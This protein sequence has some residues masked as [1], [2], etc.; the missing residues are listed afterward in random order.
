MAALPFG[1]YLLVESV[2][3]L[4][5]L[6]IYHAL[7]RVA[8]DW[9][10]PV[11][12]ERLRTKDRTAGESLLVAARRAAALVHINLIQ[13]LDSGECAGDFFVVTEPW[14]ALDLARVGRTLDPV[15]LAYVMAEAARGL[16]A[17]HQAKA[18]HGGLC[19]ARIALGIRGEVKL[20]EAE[21]TATLARVGL[22]RGERRYGPSQRDPGEPLDA[23]SELYTLGQLFLE[24][25]DGLPPRLER[26]AAR[27][28]WKDGSHRYREAV[29]LER[30]L[31][32]FLREAGPRFR[33]AD[34]GQLIRQRLPPVSVEA[35]APEVPPSVAAVVQPPSSP[36]SRSTPSRSAWIGL[37]A[38][39]LVTTAGLVW[40]AWHA[41]AG[42]LQTIA[43]SSTAQDEPV[44]TPAPP[45]LGS[46][47]V[48]SFGD[49]AERD[50]LRYQVLRCQR[51]GA[52]RAVIIRLTNLTLVP[53]EVPLARARLIGSARAP[54]LEPDLPTLPP[55]SWR[56]VALRFADL[57]SGQ[58]GTMIRLG[59][60]LDFRIYSEDCP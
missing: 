17:L 9:E 55:N 21:L 50:G 42:P 18:V 29:E 1:K 15:A 30:D 5:P 54:T 27:L 20:L 45:D 57:E 10:R 22:D 37:A 41:G 47:T 52:D 36:A 59:P 58:E 16:A 11:V 38:A 3:Q 39:L 8:E 33:R 32:D 19:P 13:L 28:V 4:G 24:A 49:S 2:G 14:P 51:L 56:D 35:D 12:V 34:L 25:S 43:D 40:T 44:A 7:Q 23:R 26:I 60:G 6:E 46:P 53:Q 31:W 48:Y